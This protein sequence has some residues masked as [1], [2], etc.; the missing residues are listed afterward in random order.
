MPIDSKTL[1]LAK[2]AIKK[3]TG[4]GSSATPEWMPTG[5]YSKDQLI[6]YLGKLYKAK[7]AIASATTSP[8]IDSAHYEVFS[9][10]GGSASNAI[11]FPDFIPGE[12][13]SFGQ[14]IVRNYCLMSAKAS[15]TGGLTFDQNDWNVISDMHKNIYDT[16]YNGIVDKAEHALVADLALETKLV[17]P[18]LQQMIKQI[19]QV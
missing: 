12:P 11:K 3:S 14:C 18:I 5:K 9:G 10:S 16:N 4:G 6:S 8:D 17:Q 2:S 19:V 13:Y 7:V 1:A 15:F